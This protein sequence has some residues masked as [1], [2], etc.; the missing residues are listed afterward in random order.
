MVSTENKRGSDCSGTDGATSRVL[1][2]ANTG[3]TVSGGFLVF[4]N[5]LSMTL[6]TEYTVSHL[7]ASSQITFT[8]Y[9][10]NSDYITVSYIQG[11]ATPTVGS[12]C[13]YD[14]VY[15][16]T[17][18][19][20]TEVSSTLVDD[21]ILDA[22]AELNADAGRVFT[23]GNSITEYLSIKDKDTIGN[24]QTSVQ[25]RNYPVQSISVFNTVDLDGTAVTTY[26]TLSAAEIV[27]G[28]YESD[29]YWLQTMYDT[30]AG[31]MVANGKVTLKTATFPKGINNVK[32]T[33]TYGYTNV[34]TIVK[35]AAVCLT[36]MRTWVIF[37][38]G[39]F[40]RIDSYSIPQQSVNKG[41]FYAK[42][43]A[44][45]EM[46]KAEYDRLMGRIGRKT[47]VMF[48]GSGDSR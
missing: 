34:P 12:Y 16:K 18:L 37:L 38:G 21:M 40:N 22:E 33:Y 30:L 43:Q 6:T 36:A 15:N 7:N 31:A 25:L 28:T 48:F 29:D 39:Q 2:L 19:S 45:M 27:A 46:L 4:V 26:D 17:G 11:T 3:L 10:W 13:D 23:T 41:N 5:G 47:N 1:T 9:I 32:A 44:Q 20:A 35:N 42:G 8:G 24:Y 14:D